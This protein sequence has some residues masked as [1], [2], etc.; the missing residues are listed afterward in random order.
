MHN[1]TPRSPNPPD[2]VHHRTLVPHGTHGGLPS[3]RMTT[4]PPA[5]GNVVTL[6][7]DTGIP[8]ID[9]GARIHH[10]NRAVPTFLLLAW[11]L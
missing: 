3:L 6:A 10:D 2:I 5:G 7:C 9:R 1:K 11:S 8:L 4:Q